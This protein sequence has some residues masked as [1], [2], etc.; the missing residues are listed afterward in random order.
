MVLA[1]STVRVVVVWVST[2]HFGVMVEAPSVRR[3]PQANNFGIIFYRE[4]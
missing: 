3:R 1:E 2:I 4:R